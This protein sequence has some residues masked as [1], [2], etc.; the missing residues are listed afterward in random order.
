MLKTCQ[1][2]L[3]AGIMY[4]PFDFLPV[5]PVDGKSANTSDS[6]N[7]TLNTFSITQGTLFFCPFLI[8]VKLTLISKKTKMMLY[9]KM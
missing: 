5:K 2:F 3:P 1:C 4:P 9:E 6:Q 8:L 7:F